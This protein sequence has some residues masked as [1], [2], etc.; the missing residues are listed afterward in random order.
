MES[1]PLYTFHKTKYGGELLIDLVTLEYIRP[2][3]LA[4]PTH[5]L[6]YHDITLITEGSGLFRID[7]H[8]YQAAPNSIIFTRPGEIRQWD[9]EGIRNGYALIFEE[10]FLLSFFNDK[11]FIHNLSYFASDRDSAQLNLDIETAQRIQDLF[12]HIREEI[13]EAEKDTH[14]L[15]A[16]LYETLM[17]LHRKYKLAYPTQTGNTGETN[18]HVHRFINLVRDNH[19]TQRSV[20][21][22][23][24]KLCLTPNYLNEI[25]TRQTG[26]NAKQH[27]EHYTVE[28]IKR[29][30][31]YTNMSITA[32]A[33]VLH[34]EN[35]SYLIRF[36]RKFA[37]QTPLQYRKATKP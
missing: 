14:I 27:I 15:R 6:S 17:L 9:K 21:Y 5:T 11:H 23:A 7:N 12:E 26:M 29:I 10:A 35:I 33:E 28:E 16:Q 18:N 25:V 4:D 37:G 13:D 36:F 20:Q 19:K 30:L 3:L 34:F 22:Y 1:I 8:T 31:T 32:I 24:D 2:Y